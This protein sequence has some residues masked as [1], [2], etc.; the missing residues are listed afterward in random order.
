MYNAQAEAY[1][2]C[3]SLVADL[4]P[5]PAPV[6]S[7]PFLWSKTHHPNTHRS[8]LRVRILQSF[9]SEPIPPPMRLSNIHA[10]TADIHEAMA[11]TFTIKRHRSCGVKCLAWFGSVIILVIFI[12]LLVCLVKHSWFAHGE[13]VTWGF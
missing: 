7:I 10:H 5:V 2:T 8:C 11:D 12:V 9:C 4:F 3:S 13:K 6:S 1:K